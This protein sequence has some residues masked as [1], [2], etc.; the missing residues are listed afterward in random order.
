ML[1]GFAVTAGRSSARPF[2][3]RGGGMENG[4]DGHDESGS[5]GKSNVEMIVPVESEVSAAVLIELQRP[6]DPGVTSHAY[7]TRIEYI[8]S[9]SPASIQVGR[10]TQYITHQDGTAQVAE[11]GGVATIHAAAIK[12]QP[13]AGV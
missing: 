8:I 5:A 11:R 13:R 9:S 10:P 6:Y 3:G 2:F 12:E 4:W 1:P 7:V